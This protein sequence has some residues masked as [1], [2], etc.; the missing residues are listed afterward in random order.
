[1]KELIQLIANQLGYKNQILRKPK[2]PADIRRHCADIKLA[3]KIMGF[4][5]KTD[6]KE[7]I[8]FTIEWYKK[9]FK[10]I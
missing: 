8:K 1:I 2:R 7:G 10:G 6:L 9:N 4:E 5:P 3:K